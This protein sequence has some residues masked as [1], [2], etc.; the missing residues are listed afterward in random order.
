MEYSRNIQQKLI[1]EAA[2]N[3]DYL[4][5]KCLKRKLSSGDKPCKKNERLVI[6]ASSLLS[7]VNALFNN[8]SS[9]VFSS[10]TIVDYSFHFLL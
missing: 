6:A 3:L 9:L 5:K 8:G 1:L 4:S 10:L 7:H 2:T